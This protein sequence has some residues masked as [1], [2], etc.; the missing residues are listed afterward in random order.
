MLAGANQALLDAVSLA[1]SLYASDFG[2]AAKT[3]NRA[4]TKPIERSTNRRHAGDEPRFT[5]AEIPD[6]APGPQ[7]GV[8]RPRSPL[9]TRRS[10][11]ATPAG[12]S[13]HEDTSPLSGV[14]EALAAYE[15][16]MLARSAVKVQVSAQ[17]ACV[18]T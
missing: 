4:A 6:T 11:V 16:E 2:A 7:R 3:H 15:S 10:A 13:A 8:Q 1:R 5:A 18:D 14:V 17:N 9:A 12:N